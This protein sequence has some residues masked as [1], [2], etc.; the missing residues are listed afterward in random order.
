MF[1]IV[2][3]SRTSCSWRLLDRRATV[4]L[5]LEHKWDS[6]KVD[7]E[8]DWL[9]NGQQKLLCIGRVRWCTIRCNCSVPL[10]PWSNALSHSLHVYP[11]VITYNLIQQQNGQSGGQHLM[12]QE[13]WCCHAECKALVGSWQDQQRH[14]ENQDMHPKYWHQQLTR[15]FCIVTLCMYIYYVWPKKCLFCTMPVIIHHCTMLVLKIYM[16]PK[17]SL[18]AKWAVATMYSFNISQQFVVTV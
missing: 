11:G 6:Q 9:H 15:A 13:L 1:S 3:R 17:M 8:M 12:T 16:S 4:W 2:R 14:R 7:L 18:I 10:L 5:L